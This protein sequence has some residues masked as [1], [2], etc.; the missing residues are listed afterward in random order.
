MELSMLKLISPPLSQ[1]KRTLVPI[2]Q[3]TG[4]AP[5]PISTWWQREESLPPLGNK[6][7]SFSL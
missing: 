3:E 6:P 7:W 5:E 1:E 2:R 4:C